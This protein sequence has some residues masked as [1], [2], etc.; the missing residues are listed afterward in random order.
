[1]CKIKYLFGRCNELCCTFSTKPLWS[2][3]NSKI[4]VHNRSLGKTKI[5]KIE[6]AKMAVD[7]IISSA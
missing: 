7:N 2:A 5:E 1:M 3:V 4:F 6:L